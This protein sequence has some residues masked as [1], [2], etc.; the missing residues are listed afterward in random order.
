MRVVTFREKGI[1][2][3]RITEKRITRT[4]CASSDAMFSH[5]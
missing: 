1:T 4:N 2:E 5:S 3:K